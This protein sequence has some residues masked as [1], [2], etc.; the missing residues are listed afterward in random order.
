MG[1]VMSKE[2]IRQFGY[3]LGADAI[4]FAA[5]EDY[6]SK[7]SPD[8]AT[9][10]PGVKSLVVLGY[11]EINGAVES[12]NTRMGMAARMGA[13]ELSLKNNYLMARHMEDHYQVKAAGVPVSYPLDMSPE[14]MGFTGDVSLRHAAVAAG[15]G[16][17][18]RHNLVINPRFGTRIIFTAVLTELP[19]SSDPPV[20]EELCT[21][22]DLCVEV[23]PA[24][25]LDEEGKTDMFRCLTVSQ[26]YGIRG[27][28]RYLR[29]FIGASPEEQKALLKDPRLLHIYQAQFIGFQ[30]FCIKCMA[31][32][33]VCIE[34]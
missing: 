15:L 6:Q 2:Q 30:Y 26:P 33:P 19:L 14:V 9:I 24:H 34:A 4:G 27:T 12:E 8:P 11:R 3:E 13:M 25:A 5:I 16:V 7:K 28:V 17:F 22:C 1:G 10:L 31:V 23:C 29:Q 32:C 18:G 21:R 20:Q